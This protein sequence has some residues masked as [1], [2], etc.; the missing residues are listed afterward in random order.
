MNFPVSWRVI[1][2]MKR[3]MQTRYRA[4]NTSVGSLAELLSRWNRVIIVL[5]TLVMLKVLVVILL[6]YV[7]YFPARFDTG[8]LAGRQSYFFGVYRWAFIVHVIT[9]PC[10]LLLGRILIS[11]SF[12]RKLSNTHRWL[13]RFH[14]AV[15]LLGLVPSGLIM[16]NH[17]EYGPWSGVGL[18]CLALAT[19]IATLLGWQAAVQKRFL[20]HRLWMSR[21]FWLLCSTIFLRLMGVAAGILHWNPAWT[22]P[23]SVWLSWIL[24]LA[25]YEIVRYSSKSIGNSTH[26][27]V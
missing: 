8:F 25:V 5:A 26:N 15:V 1:S 10:C 18:A 12:R 7:N 9:G 14:V 11:Q 22:Y 23:L 6:N 3:F 20:A 2:N 19:G 17:A 13:G 16:A 4:L 24:P 21:C 27:R